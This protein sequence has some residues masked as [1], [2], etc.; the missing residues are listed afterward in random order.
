MNTLEIGLVARPHGVRGE[1][2]LKLHNPAS[3]TLFEVPRVVLTVASETPR[4]YEVLSVRRAGKAL[5]L[6]L[7]GVGSCELAEGLRGAIVS[8]D[9]ELL[10]DLEPDEYYL[11][12]LVGCQVMGPEGLVGRVIEVHSHPTLDSMVILTPDEGRL[13]QPLD[14]QWLE[15]VSVQERSIVLSTLDGLIR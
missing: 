1:L 14:D 4:E 5:L 8:V 13:E 10:P 2:R 3:V 7:E 6:R 11:A 12:D 15:R 9:R